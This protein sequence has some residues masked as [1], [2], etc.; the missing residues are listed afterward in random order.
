MPAPPSLCSLKRCYVAPSAMGVT[1]DTITPGAGPVGRRPTAPAHCPGHASRSCP[2]P[3]PH[4]ASLPPLCAVAGDGATFPKPGQKVKVRGVAGGAHEDGSAPPAPFAGRLRGSLPPC[5]ESTSQ[6]SPVGC[7]P[8]AACPLAAGL[9][10]WCTCG[11]PRQHAP[12]PTARPRSNR[13]CAT[14]T[15]P[16][17]GHAHKRQQV[18]QQ[19]RP[20][21]AL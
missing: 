16:L 4:P 7:L 10:P 11:K 19:P 18:R 14:A 8:V 9:P 2:T 1:K 12:H 13:A 3:A 6:R 15:G 17:R 21:V 5:F 20:R